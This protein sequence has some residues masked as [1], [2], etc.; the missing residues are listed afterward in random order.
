MRKFVIIPTLLAAF[1]CAIT[2]PAAEPPF[3]KS[4]RNGPGEKNEPGKGRP[5]EKK[6]SLAGRLAGGDP[7]RIVARMIE[8]FDKDGDEKLDVSEL[9]ALFTSIRERSDGS[10]LMEKLRPSDR[11]ERQVEEVGGDLPTR[12]APE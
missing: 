1:A 2:G 11:K 7:A 9:T 12:P 6:P 8:Q 5:G 3:D 10:P 4:K